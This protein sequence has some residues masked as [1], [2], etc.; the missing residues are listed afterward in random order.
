MTIEQLKAKFMKSS[1]KKSMVGYA[2]LASLQRGITAE[3]VVMEISELSDAHYKKNK[4]IN[5]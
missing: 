5:N 4:S 2:M 1:V 3:R